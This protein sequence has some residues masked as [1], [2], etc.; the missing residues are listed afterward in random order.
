MKPTDITPKT[1]HELTILLTDTRK[2]LGQLT[3]EM[4][5]KQTKNVKQI[6]GLKRTVARVLTIQ[7]ERALKELK[8]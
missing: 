7:R 8:S 5:T 1:D 4:R 2:Q 6:R 3:L